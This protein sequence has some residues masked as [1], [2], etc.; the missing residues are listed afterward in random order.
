FLSGKPWRELP[1]DGKL[2][3]ALARRSKGK[4]TYLHQQQ[5]VEHLLGPGC[6]PLVVTTG[7]GS[8]KTECFLAPLLQA[9][10]EDAIKQRGVPGLVGLVLYPMNALANDQLER[11]EFYLQ[12]SGYGDAVRVAMYNR[13]TKEDERERLR[14]RPPHLLLTNYQMLEYLLVRPQDR[15]SLFAGHRCRFVVLDEVHTYRGTLGT[16]VALL[17]RRFR[18]HLRRANPQTPGFIT[19]GTSATIRS[20]HEVKPGTTFDPAERDRAVQRFCGKWVGIEP[21]G[22]RVVGELSEVLTPPTEAGYAPLPPL[23]ATTDLSDA[24]QLRVALC[25]LAGVPETTSLIEASKR[26]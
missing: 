22:V 3:A 23:A 1:L 8:G 2:A 10:I 24:E 4:P 13:G 7:T 26:C 9:A 17:L 12:E 25:R 6:S 14:Q 21:T 5:A 18:A 16:H 15:E 11:I 20:E 19:I